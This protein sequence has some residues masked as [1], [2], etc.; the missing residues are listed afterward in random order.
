MS[1]IHVEVVARGN[2][3]VE[4]MLRRFTRKCKKEEIVREVSE[5][6]EFRSKKEK[7]KA[8]SEKRR[9]RMRQKTSNIE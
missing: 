9:R 1:T 6:S 3:P 5:R 7:R 4:K 8:K 2:E